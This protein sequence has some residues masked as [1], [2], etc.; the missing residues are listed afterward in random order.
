M[1]EEE[2]KLEVQKLQTYPTYSENPFMEQAIE[3]VQKNVV[4]KYKNATNTGE[5]AILQA[6]DPNTGEVLGA[7]SFVRQIE[8]DEEQ[9]IKIYLNNFQSFFDLSPKAIR[10]FGYLIE[11]LMIGKDVVLFNMNKALKYTKYSSKSTIYSGLAELVSANIIARG[12]TDGIFFV[13]P[14]CLFNGNR[15]TYVKTYVKMKKQ[16]QKEDPNQLSFMNQLESDP[17]KGPEPE[18]YEGPDRI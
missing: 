8:V 14:M 4:K 11:N 16:Q 3:V 13:N 6:I 15:L 5:K 12:W 18:S 17:L 10:V 1:Q 2:H 7:T 9:F